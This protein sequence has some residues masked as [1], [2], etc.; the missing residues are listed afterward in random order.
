MRKIVR[1]KEPV[2]NT[3]RLMIYTDEFGTYLF[4]YHNLEDG[5]ADWDESIKSHI[6][7]LA[8]CK[9]RYGLERTDWTE[10]DNPPDKCLYDWIAPVRI[11]G[12]AEGKPEMGKFEKLVDGK[13]IEVTS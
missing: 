7:A 10:I 4:G 6:E 13:W 12:R 8:V 1:L 11:K 2:E 5:P 9:E 3:V